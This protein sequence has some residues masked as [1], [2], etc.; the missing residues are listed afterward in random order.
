M[1]I[2]PYDAT[3]LRWTRLCPK[4]GQHAQ[5]VVRLIP[6]CWTPPSQQAKITPEHLSLQCPCGHELA[7]MQTMETL[8]NRPPS[9]AL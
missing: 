4:C 5:S 7:Q 2:D 1:K 9:R 8:Q 6:E 3:Q